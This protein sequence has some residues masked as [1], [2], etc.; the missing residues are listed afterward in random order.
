MKTPPLPL[1]V[2]AILAF[3]SGS[4]APAVAAPAFSIVRGT[5]PLEES[6]RIPLADLESYLARSVPGSETTV[7]NT[8]AD[9]APSG[10]VIV[11]VRPDDD[12]TQKL[13]AAYPATPAPTDWNSFTLASH[14]LRE[15]AT[16]TIYFLEGADAAGRQYAVYDFIERFLGVRFLHPDFEHVP[17][18]TAF[19]PAPINTGLQKPDFKWRGLYPWNYHYNARGLA[20]FCDINARFVAGDWDWFRRL[21]DWMVKNKQNTFFWFDDVFGAQNLSARLPASV[22]DYYAQRGLRQVLGLGWAANEGRPRGGDW[23]K[24]ICLDAAGVSVEKKPDRESICPEVPEYFELADK[25]LAEL[26]L[27][28]AS[29]LGVLIG[30]GETTWA[31]HESGNG[32]ALHAHTPTSQLMNR[33]VDS[34][35]AKLRHAGA[36][37]LPVGFV[38]SSYSMFWD[39]PFKTGKIISHLP[40]NGIVSMHTYQQDSWKNFTPV[41]DQIRRRN[42]TE[43]TDIKIFEIAEV[44]FLCNHD[45]PLLRPSILR[46]REAHFRSLPREDVI[47]HLTT[48]NTTQYLYWYLNYQMMRWQWHIDDQSW[49]ETSSALFRDIFGPDNGAKFNDLLGRISCLDNVQPRAAAETLG[50]TSAEPKNPP[51]WAR[52]NAKA[53]SPDFGFFL[54][55]DIQDLDLLHDAEANI[56]ACLAL[57]DELAAMSDPLYRTHFRT[58]VALTAHY[59]ALRVQA[60]KYAWHLARARSLSAGKDW[61]PEIAAQLTL[62]RAA[63]EKGL[64]SL[65]AYHAPSAPYTRDVDMVLNPKPDYFTTRIATLDAALR[66]QNAE[67]VPVE[68]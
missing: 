64:A 40:A 38:I 19:V 12:A 11:L 34:I 66:S 44:S 33:D 57:N 27:K 3:V 25:N 61:S 65:T 51:Q 45:I 36:P 53:H 60:G 22:R 10:T 24:K 37:D 50:R 2:F 7:V 31:T 5:A 39:S 29:P 17:V 1:L 9:I 41:F 59:H 68:K 30:Y 15:D 62:A 23:E 26:D 63:L 47:G 55:R 54:W 16:R 20:T 21:G 43:N 6:L 46:R 8:A 14:P 28:S 13:R 56:A 4:A 58:T 32:C 18:H 49:G 35:A 48:L 52:Y 67:L 42:E